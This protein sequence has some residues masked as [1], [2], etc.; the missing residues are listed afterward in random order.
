[1][2][3]SPLPSNGRSF[4]ACV[5]FARMCLPSRCLANVYIRHNTLNQV[6][7]FSLEHVHTINA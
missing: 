7:A 6:H 4:V 2:F 5:R 3:T 1:M